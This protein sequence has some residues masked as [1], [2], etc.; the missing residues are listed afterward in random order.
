M[1]SEKDALIRNISDTALWV[2]V[3]RAQ[4]TERK[5]AWFRDP[6][7]KR[8][9]G[10]RGERI[11]ATLPM[12]KD[13]AWSMVTRTVLVDRFVTEQVKEGTDLVINLAAGLDTRPY[14]MDLPA[15]LRW[16]EVDLPEILAYKEEILRGEKPVCQL[17]RVAMDLS[18]GAARREFF[19]AQGQSARRAM[20]ITEGLLIYLFAEEVASLARDMATAP[21][22]QAWIL[23][24]AS[25]GLMRMLEKKIGPQLSQGNAPFKFAPLEGVEF[26]SHHGWEASDVRSLLKTAARLKRLPLFLRIIALLPEKKGPAGSRPWSGVCLLRKK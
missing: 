25:P 24:L 8:L 3:Y 4:E 16:V 1:M 17:E 5:D 9:A 13:S 6:Y 21:N 22:F 7:A 23:D 11:A 18:N 14:R 26:F 10:E 2:A 12:A 15:T 19:Q 20:I